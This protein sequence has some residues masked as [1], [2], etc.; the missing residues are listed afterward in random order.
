M[1]RGGKD[2]LLI[3][4]DEFRVHANDKENGISVSLLKGEKSYVYVE[5]FCLICGGG[6]RYRLFI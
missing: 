3:V 5:V 4:D 1:P 2:G 6:C